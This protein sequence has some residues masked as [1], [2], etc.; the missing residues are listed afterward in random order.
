MSM[1]FQ[2]MGII[3]QQI[4]RTHLYRKHTSLGVC[5]FFCNLY[6]F[7]SFYVKNLYNSEIFIY[8]A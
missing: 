2:P 6:F 1:Y 7:S 8:F 3:R 5:L 4:F